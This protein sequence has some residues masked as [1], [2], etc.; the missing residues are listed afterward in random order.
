MV[1]GHLYHSGFVVELEEKT[2]LFD[3]YRTE[4]PGYDPMELRIRKDK[5][6]YVFVSHAHA[7]HFTK[8]IFQIPRI[9][10]GTD[11][12]YVVDNMVASFAP[13]DE[14]LDIVSFMPEEVCDID[15]DVTVTSLDSTDLGL[16]YLVEVDGKTIFHAGDLNVWWWPE[17][18]LAEN[19]E[20][21]RRYRQYLEPIEGMHVDVAF[22]PITPKA[23]ADGA[24]GIEAFM[25]LVGADVIVP[26]H[27]RDER[28]AAI[29]L[30]KGY[31]I[32]KWF[33][34]MRFEDVF[35]L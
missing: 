31:R 17:R 1:I 23:G 28:D 11:P 29:A 16:A 2:L 35:E 32:G 10:P 3:W 4:L 8:A 5:K 27:Y 26:M 14:D 18:S 25:E 7:D 12:T 24:R 21:E 22:L 13:Q 30:A 33:G 6:L 19:E 34:R 15:D 9:M 20:S